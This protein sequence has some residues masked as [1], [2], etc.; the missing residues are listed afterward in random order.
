MEK[1]DICNVADWFLTH[2]A[3]TH[4]KLQKMLYFSYG[5]FLS[6]YNENSD[7]LTNEIFCNDFEAW[8]H[9]PV[10]PKIYSL[11]RDAGYNYIQKRVVDPIVISDEVEEVLFFVLKKYKEYNGDDLEKI[12]HS[13]MPWL[14]A[15]IGLL[16]IE[17]SNNSISSMDIYEYFKDN[18][19]VIKH[20]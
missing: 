4:K 7:E 15:R 2:E 18:N 14:K 3:M 8:V 20:G 17:P 11:Y 16:P 13:Q 5:Y 6:T 9:G 10:S 12:T 19:L 1:L